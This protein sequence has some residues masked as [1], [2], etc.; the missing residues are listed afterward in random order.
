M[1]MDEDK[2]RRIVK[3]VLCERDA[4]A[5]YSK[6]TQ[7]QT[8]YIYKVGLI[9]RSGVL[10]VCVVSSEKGRAG[11]LGYY[12][13]PV[14]VLTEKEFCTYNDALKWVVENRRTIEEYDDKIKFS[15]DVHAA[16]LRNKFD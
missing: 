16:T 6:P 2:V 10:M 15:L 7:P 5:P 1:F 12:N 9:E 3:D 11:I 13:T 4:K 8:V 14:Y